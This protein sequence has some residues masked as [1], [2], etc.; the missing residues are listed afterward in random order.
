MRDLTG[1]YPPTQEVVDKVHAMFMHA[2]RERIKKIH[3]VRHLFYP[4][5]GVMLKLDGLSWKKTIYISSRLGKDGRTTTLIHELIH[6]V[7][8]LSDRKKDE[9]KTLKAEA[10]LFEKFSEAQRNAIWRF[11]PQKVTIENVNDEKLP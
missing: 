6:F 2:L 5:P 7:F 8:K 1:A 9:N 3:L 11:I 10:R 4:G